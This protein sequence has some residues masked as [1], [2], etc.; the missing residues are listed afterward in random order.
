MATWLLLAIPLAWG[1]V[2]TRTRARM[3]GQATRGGRRIAL[4]Q[5]LDAT[6]VWQTGAVITMVST[7]FLSLSR[8]G[9]IGLLAAVVAG[10][11]F[12]FIR[13]GKVKLKWLA[14]VAVFVTVIATF[15]ANLV[16]LTTR[17]SEFLDLG[18]ERV[19][20]WRQTMPIVHDFAFA[21][22]GQGTFART[23]LFYQQGD[24]EQL[25]NQA[26]N[27]YLQIASEGGLLVGI[28]ALCV[29]VLF[30]ALMARA[31]KRDVTARFWMRAGAAA[32]IVAV[33]VQSVWE[34]GLRMPANGVLFAV[35]AALAV[36]EAQGSGSEQD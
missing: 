14:G 11:S 17:F 13:F 2:M 15:L 6:T 28:P 5:A 35:C 19:T 21:G 33:A 16:A 25:F 26:H 20:I 18:D 1:Y 7:L 10:F 29:L 32:G 24:K 23:M 34:T 9:T 36:H 22:T 31:L 30:V 3:H 12:T 4:I 8:S 27:Q